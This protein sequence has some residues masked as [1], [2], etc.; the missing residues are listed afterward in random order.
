MFGF[1]C[2]GISTVCFNMINWSFPLRET[3]GQSFRRMYCLVLPAGRW[4]LSTSA[5]LD[6]RIAIFQF[7]FNCKLSNCLKPEI[8]SAPL[9]PF[10]SHVFKHKQIIYE[11]GKHLP[12]E[13]PLQRSLVGI[14]FF[15]LFIKALLLSLFKIQGKT[16]AAGP[17]PRGSDHLTYICSISIAYCTIPLVALWAYTFPATRIV[18]LTCCLGT[19]K[20]ENWSNTQETTP[21]RVACEASY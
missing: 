9:G 5:G 2:L 15:W 1:I 18:E 20:R 17:V 6:S 10:P 19:R 14:I 7:V 13:Y 11:S 3:A 8:C 4:V 16:C 12:L 21:A